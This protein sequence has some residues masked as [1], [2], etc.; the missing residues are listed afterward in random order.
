MTID[1]IMYCGT[2]IDKNLNCESQ[3]EV[4]AAFSA[5]DEG[6]KYQQ[7]LQQTPCTTQWRL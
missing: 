1:D 4:D 6:M 5:F 2:W 3:A 7:K